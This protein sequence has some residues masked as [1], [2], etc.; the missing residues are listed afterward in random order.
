MNRLAI[1]P[2]I[3]L[4]TSILCMSHLAFAASDDPKPK[5]TETTKVCKDGE[6]W[7]KDKKKCVPMKDSR[8]SDE[9][10]FKSARELAY[11][12]RH[13]DA[14]ALLNKASNTQDPRILNYLGLSHRKA[15]DFDK[16]INYYTQALTIDPNYNLARSYMGQGYLTIGETYRAY[17]Q[18]QEIEKRGGNSTWAY[19][20]LESAIRGENTYY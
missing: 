7:D 14:I 20:S 1:I 3:L 5:P 8:L 2:N 12:D 18:L 19:R 15:G 13:Q 9:Q 17:E 11:A 4:A 16:A 6:V 10:I